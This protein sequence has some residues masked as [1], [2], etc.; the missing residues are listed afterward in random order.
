MQQQIFLFG[1]RLYPIKLSLIRWSKSTKSVLKTAVNLVNSAVRSA[2]KVPRNSRFL[3]QIVR[4]AKNE[5]FPQKSQSEDESKCSV[6]VGQTL[7]TVLK[8][9]PAICPEN[10]SFC[11]MCEREKICPIV[12]RINEKRREK[13]CV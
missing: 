6:N 13:K 12:V 4:R 3:C 5:N 9:G 1:D 11:H 2:V 7:A 8:F 10:S